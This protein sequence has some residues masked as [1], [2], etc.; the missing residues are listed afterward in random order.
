LLDLSKE[1]E[2]ALNRGKVLESKIKVIL[3]KE[4]CEIIHV[5]ARW[6]IETYKEK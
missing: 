1:E 2:Q 5:E 6:N 3:K 4:R